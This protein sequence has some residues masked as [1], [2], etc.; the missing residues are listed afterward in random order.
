MSQISKSIC[1]LHPSLLYQRG[2]IGPTGNDNL[3]IRTR[4]P[5]IKK[6]VPKIATLNQCQSQAM[7]P[8]IQL[9]P[10]TNAMD[11]HRS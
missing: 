7:Y 6:N 8:K 4:L 2:S 1:L 5:Q 9:I 11:Q 10:Q 3:P